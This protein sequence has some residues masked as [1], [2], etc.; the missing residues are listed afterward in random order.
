MGVL[1]SLPLVAAQAQMPVDNLA[2]KG[3][4]IRLNAMKGAIEAPVLDPAL[5]QSAQ[6]VTSEK[7][8]TMGFDRARAKEHYVACTM[9]YMAAI[10]QRAGNGGVKPNPRSA[11]NLDVVALAE[12]Q[13]AQQQ[14]LT[15]VEHVKRA[16]VELKEVAAKPLT[17]EDS[18][19]IIHAAS[20][21][22]VTSEA[23][24]AAAATK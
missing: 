8:M 19:Q 12:Y 3:R 14:K 11:H 7:F 16:E 15:M 18:A 5:A 21:L 20:V 24:A 10:A 4:C 2:W 22:P 6:G 23:A 1:L 13:L 17:A 9:F